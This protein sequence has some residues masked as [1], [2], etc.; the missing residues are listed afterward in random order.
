M[1]F[2]LSIVEAGKR[3]CDWRFIA[4]IPF[5]DDEEDETR[6]PKKEA[7]A[8]ARLIAAAPALLTACQKAIAAY[9]AACINPGAFWRGEDIDEMKDAI[10]AAKGTA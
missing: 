2:E 8:N 4:C 7:A 5:D 9:E 10:A 6:I 1:G 3:S